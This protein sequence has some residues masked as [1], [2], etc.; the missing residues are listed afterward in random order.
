[1]QFF[2]IDEHIKKCSITPY[3]NVFNHSI[4]QFL[5]NSNRRII[6]ITDP[7]YNQK[8]HYNSYDD[9]LQTSEY[10][11]LLSHIK[12]PCVIIHYPEETINLLPKAIKENCDD[13]LTWVYNGNTWKNTRLISFWGCKP[14]LNK[15]KQPYKNPNDSRI[16]KLILE[17]KTGARSYDWLNI[18]QVKN[19]SKEKT[20]HPCQI[21]LE[22]MD[23]VIKMVSQPNDIIFDPFSGSGT[24]AL[25]S[26]NNNLDF[27]GFDIDYDYTKLSNHRI[28]LWRSENESL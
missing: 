1:M 24:T 6:T 20:S 14:D 26:L 16:K 28:K 4:T 15:V 19:I 18:N 12:P 17:G 9:N 13:V 3:A 25:A 21:P 22:L 2:N 27:I 10:I 23:K 5:P 8:Y 7:P 11:E